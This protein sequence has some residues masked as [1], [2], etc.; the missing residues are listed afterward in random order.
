[1]PGEIHDEHPFKSP[2]EQ[3][4]PVRQFRGRLAAPVTVVTSGGPD[5]RAGLTVSS[6]MVAEG[7]PSYVHFLAGSATDLWFAVQ[8]RGT[9]VVHI[10]EAG[11]R[12]LSDR[13]AGIRPSP[14]GLFAGLDVEDTDWGPVIVPLRSRAYC[15]YVGHRDDPLH[16]LVHGVVDQVTLH[17]LREPLGYF[18]GE[19]VTG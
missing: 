17:D 15:H 1:M 8:E 10:L 16:A 12:D 7:E 13:F 9:F 11:H 18:R 19:Y 4:D 14:G 3:R 6:L 5:S 2:P